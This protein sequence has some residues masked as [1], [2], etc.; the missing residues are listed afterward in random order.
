MTFTS[1]ITL[2][3]LFIEGLETGYVSSPQ[4]NSVQVAGFWVCIG[5][6]SFSEAKDTIFQKIRRGSPLEFRNSNNY[7]ELIPKNLQHHDK[8]L[9]HSSST[10]CKIIV[11]D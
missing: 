11:E 6:G 5:V 7:E 10:E 9:L 1:V 3:F 8:I 4:I 2:L